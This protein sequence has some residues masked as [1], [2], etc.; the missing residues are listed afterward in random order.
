MLEEVRKHLT[1]ETMGPAP[2]YLLAVSGGVDSMVLWHMIHHLNLSY[3]VAHVNFG[4]RDQES[5]KDANLVEAL[6]RQRNVKF[7]LYKLSKE[8]SEAL[9]LSSV[10]E[11]ARD[12]RYRWFTEIMKKNKIKC[13]LTAHHLDDSIETFFLNLCRGSGLK[14]LCGI[15]ERPGIKRPLLPFTKE[16]VRQYAKQHNIAYREDHTNRENAYARNGLRN[17]LL[18]LFRQQYPAFQ[19]QMR[20]TLTHLQSAY[21]VYHSALF[22]DSHLLYLQASE[23]GEV[24]F[25][26]LESL[27]HGYESL[28]Y[29][30]GEF[31]FN[32]A[33]SD[34]IIEAIRGEKTGALFYSAEHVL[35]ID[36]ERLLLKP[37][38][39]NWE[40]KIFIYRNTTRIDEPICLLM[41]ES[42]HVKI[43]P[44]PDT[45]CLDAE[46]LTYPLILRKWQDGDKFRPLGMNGM[47]KVSDFLIDEK[48]NRLQKQQTFVLLSGD[49]IVWVV[50]L[51]ADDRFKINPQTKRM[52][53]IKYLR[54]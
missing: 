51:R 10:Q 20:L 41:E 18:P 44:Q 6:A 50:G 12:I 29:L 22:S 37:K 9:K 38:Q 26:Q 3:E 46:K 33:Q 11:S 54:P 16:E 31:G 30:L 39:Q 36:R 34:Q 47:K 32:Y 45:A 2:S 40:E 35:N 28:A 5:E 15:R 25:E 4:L 17:E 19:K 27:D 1:A 8:E 13:L 24:R 23:T 48:V 52:V 53:Q 43:V 7:H 49:E 42:S 14:G 21:E